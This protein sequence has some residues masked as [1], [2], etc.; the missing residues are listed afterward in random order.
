[1]RRVGFTLVELLIVIIIIAVLASVAIPKFKD[2]RERAHESALRAKLQ[3]VRNAVSRAIADTGY[4]PSKLADLTS[5]T[6]PD[7]ML[8]SELNV[9]MPNAHSWKGPYIDRSTA[10]VA[11]D[12][13][14]LTDPVC[15]GVFLYMTARKNRFK[16]GPCATGTATDG[17]NI[18]AW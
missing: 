18:A 3:T 1:V 14:N 12:G 8:D 6:P 2:S 13:E 4:L 11:L 17:T 7:E 5:E 15:G 9:V 10:G 16:I